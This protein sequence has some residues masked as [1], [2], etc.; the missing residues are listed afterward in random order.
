MDPEIYLHLA[1]Q[2]GEVDYY[3]ITDLVPGDLRGT[4]HAETAVT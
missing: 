4:A 3:H 2:K 1:T